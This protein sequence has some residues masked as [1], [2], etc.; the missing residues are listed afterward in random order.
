MKCDKC[1]GETRQHS[2]CACCGKDL[3]PEC[4]HDTKYGASCSA[5][6]ARQLR[7]AKGVRRRR[8]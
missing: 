2:P 4:R 3:C 5:V 7:K 8:W 1:G 6:C